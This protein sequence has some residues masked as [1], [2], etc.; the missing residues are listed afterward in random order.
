MRVRRVEPGGSTLAHKMRTGEDGGGDGVFETVLGEQK[1][2]I[3]EA[4]AET[5]PLV[6]SPIVHEEEV[7]DAGEYVRLVYELHHVQ[8]PELDAAGVV[9]FDR[10]DDTVTRGPQF[11]ENQSF[12]T[13][14]GEHRFVPS[15]PVEDV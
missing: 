12:C 4:L 3:V 10:E 14:N 2:R 6:A 1:Q 9:V 7:L 8:L 11:E 15:G 5:A 13:H